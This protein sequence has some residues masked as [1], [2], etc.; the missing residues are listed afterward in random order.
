M[1]IH[2]TLPVL[3]PALW[4]A[5]A[6][7]WAAIY[8]WV[9]ENGVVNYSTTLPAKPGLPA[10][11]LDANE[12]RLSVYTPVKP[13][14]GRRGEAAT[15]ALRA[16]VDQ[17]EQQLAAERRQ[18]AYS[19]QT[20][21]DKRSRTIEECIRARRVDCGPSRPSSNFTTV[22]PHPVIIARPAR[23]ITPTLFVNPPVAPVAPNPGWGKPS[24]TRWK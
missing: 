10:R 8:K 1:R 4:L 14:P 12:S 11:A 16:R 3:I 24:T 20:A 18:R 5:A 21:E 9:D 2:R 15:D 19:S 7:V 13:E 17:L 6:P 22:Y 23:T